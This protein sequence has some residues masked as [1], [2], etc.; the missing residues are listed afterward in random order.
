VCDAATV[1]HVTLLLLWSN[2]RRRADDAAERCVST[3]VEFLARGGQMQKRR[4][5]RLVVTADDGC[6]AIVIH[7]IAT[8]LM[9]VRSVTV[10]K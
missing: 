5:Q 6:S 8:Q 4:L 3:I 1:E 10:C 7:A 9:Q 2:A